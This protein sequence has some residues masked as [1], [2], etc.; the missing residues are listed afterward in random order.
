VDRP[1]DVVSNNEVG[2]QLGRRVSQLEAML[3]QPASS[4]LREVARV[5]TDAAVDGRKAIRVYKLRGVVAA[6]REREYRTRQMA[7]SALLGHMKAQGDTITPPEDWEGWEGFRRSM[8]TRDEHNV[9]EPDEIW[10][11]RP[12]PFATEVGDLKLA[13]SF[14]AALDGLCA[15]ARYHRDTTRHAALSAGKALA[16]FDRIVNLMQSVMKGDRVEERLT[17]GLATDLGFDDDDEELAG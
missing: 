10:R 3:K 6:Q 4:E 7:T 2:R 5:A 17:S 8:R 12:V 13:R 9:P 15:D 16:M 11:A 14:S 1:A